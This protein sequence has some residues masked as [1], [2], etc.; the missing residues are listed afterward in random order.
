V[1][2]T[3]RAER[4]APAWL[5]R[6]AYQDRTLG[7]LKSGKEAEVFLVERR[8]DTRACLLAHKRFR[9]RHPKKGE[10]LELGFT[11]GAIYRHDSVYRQ[12]WHLKARDERA[13]RAGTAHGQDVRARLWPAN[14]M[15]MLARAWGIGASVPYPVDRTEDG[16][17][18]E[19]IGDVDG[20]APRLVQAGLSRREVRAARDQLLGD[21]GRLATE[22]IVHADL[23]VYNVLWWRD[24]VVL[25]DFPQAVDAR[26]N[27]EAPGLLQRDLE[28]VAAWFGR[29][30]APIDADAEFAR[31]LGPLLGAGAA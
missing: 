4:P 12:G 2:D 9:P 30:G 6:E 24:R 22:G 11:H 18:M 28:N 31:L 3:A 17:L 23:S 14:E 16:I 26:T 20:A 19:L 7:V 29:R 27:A 21:L 1:P 8:D 25:I 5:V 10:L 15:E 13:I